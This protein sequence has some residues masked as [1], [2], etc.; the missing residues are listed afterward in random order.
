[1]AQVIAANRPAGA[2]LVCGGG[3]AGISAA[4]EL[5]EAGWQVTLLEARSSLGGRVSFP[6]ATRRA[7][8]C[9]TTAS[10]S[11]SAPAPT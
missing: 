7:G 5:A 3:L 2:A 11:S 10:T 8:G 4:K 1:M 9:W 6:F